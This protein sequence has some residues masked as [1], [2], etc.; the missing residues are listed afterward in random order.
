MKKNILSLLLVAGGHLF[1]FAQ[2]PG[3]IGFSPEAAQK[4]GALEKQY[5]A[6]LSAPEI[7][8]AI[9]N[10][11]AFPHHLGSAES[12][13][14]ADSIFKRLSAYGW[15][16]RMD[17]YHVLFPTPKTRILEM[18]A[19]K[20]YTALLKEPAL[21]EDATSGQKGQLPTY[22]AWSADG[23]VS[24]AL[25]F[26]N[27]GLPEDYETLKQLGVDVKGKI[28][29]AKY[30]RS[31]RGI[32]PKVAQEHGAIGC[33]IYSDPADDGYAAGDVYPKGAYKNEYG[34]QRG[35]VM[36][37][38]IRIGDPLTP[39]YGSTAD[40]KRIDRSEA[41]NLLKI[42]T[43]PISYR[44]A[45]PLLSALEGRVAP[46]DW[47]GGLPITYH[48]GD[49]ETK[50]RLKLSF[51]WDIVPCYN[52]VATIP[53][54]EY[55]DEWIIRGNHHDAW[56]NGAADPISGVASL[57]EEAKAMGALLKTGWKPKRTIVYCA[58]DGEEPAMLGS[59]EFVEDRLKE[60]QQK[61]VVYINTDNNTRGFLNAGGSHALQTMMNE[62][63]RDVTDPQ[64]NATVLKRRL[65]RTAANA[66]SL[67]GKKDAV[68][69]NSITLSP[70]GSGSDYTAFLQHAGIPSLNLGYGG[71]GGGGEYHSIYD[72]Y[73]HY[74]RFK[75]PGF[76]YGVA[77]AKTV[78][79]AV[80]RLAD[81]EILPFNYADLFAAVNDYT[82]QVINLT[83]EMRQNAL[84]EKQLHASGAYTLAADPTRRILAPELK[85]AVPHLD[86]SPLQNALTGLQ[87][88]ADG[89]K[90]IFKDVASHKE[91]YKKLNSILYR[92][93]QQL[94]L[95][96]GLPGRS[97]YKHAIYAPGLYTGYGVKTLP[98][99]R[100]SIEQH[101]W[102]QAQ[103]E[104]RAVAEAINQLTAHLQAVSQGKK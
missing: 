78:G 28:V 31:W 75:D 53:G 52:V 67:S 49:G 71:E 82:K 8:V 15:T 76:A 85:G 55:P 1:S 39:S 24:G 77:L 7:G 90:G 14:V 98:G 43:L 93:E 5:D 60:L 56:V 81:A 46:R 89:L 86:F 100:E 101:Q 4:Q 51:N 10:L 102:E 99:I 12:K 17:T 30:G 58:W 94:L 92:G 34:V 79:R 9:K 54:T 68:A 88:C 57:L 69:Q 32:K 6:V 2:T 61:A 83:D 65:A 25:V 72:T 63:A 45:L 47:V 80:L 20:K 91:T 74:R 35:S 37:L 95:P 87:Q 73:D 18:I 66:S 40:A 21:K 16:V 70:L 13:A 50:I 103:Q 97:W 36:D 29:I 3:I 19:P 62:V 38:P 44:D 41:D 64:T 48:I 84:V 96:K 23:D 104:I 42:P 11:S 26:V 33:I 22:N 27:Y 59:T